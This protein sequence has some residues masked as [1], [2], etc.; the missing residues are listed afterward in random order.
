METGTQGK[1][2]PPRVYDEAYKIEAVKLAEKIGSKK[3][4]AELGIPENTMYGW[5]RKRRE[6][7]IKIPGETAK[8]ETA[9]TLADENSRL[10]AE[11]RETQRQLAEEREVNEILDKAARFF[12]LSRKK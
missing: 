5:I 3:A 6:G 8:P 10:K 4:A 1:K 7:T 2:V 11:L 9:N 12:A